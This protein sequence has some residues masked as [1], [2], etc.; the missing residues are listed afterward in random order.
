MRLE[1]RNVSKIYSGKKV[2]SNIYCEFNAGIYG[3]LGPNGAG[4]STLMNIISDNLSADEGN[5][6]YDGNLINEMGR[7][8]R[9]KLGYMPQQQ[10][11]Y[12]GFSVIR[13]MYYM[14]T[15]R[16]M[17]KKE[18]VDRSEAVLK[19]VNMW[20]HKGKKLGELSGGMRQRVLLAQTILDNPEIL[21]LDEPTAGLDPEE[22]IRIRNLISKISLNRIVLYSTH[23]VSDIEFIADKIICLKKGVLIAQNEP[24][25]LYKELDGK[26]FLVELCEDELSMLPAGCIISSMAKT[27]EKK[28][29]VR[30]ITDNP[31]NGVECLPVSANLEDVYLSLFQGEKE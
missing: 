1:I 7:E 30:I 28:L 23:V 8:Y 20:E 2:L 4:K 11:M 3:I 14:G 18:I 26:V 17:T 19:Q 12:M 16:G 24:I 13:F 27:R 9:K 6:L 21:L 25:E 10:R 15:L 31:L 5:V 29:Q 22:R